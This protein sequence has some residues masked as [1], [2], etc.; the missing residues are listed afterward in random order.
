MTAIAVVVGPGRR[1]A[2]SSRGRPS[3][4][5]PRCSA[6]CPPPTRRRSRPSSPRPRSPTSSPTAA[7][8]SWSRR[9][10][11]T[12]SGSRSAGEG[13]PA[14]NGGGD[15][16]SLLDKQSITSSRLPAAGDLPAR[17]RRRAAP[18]PSRPSTACRPPV[19]HLAV[20]QHDV[21][22]DER[23]RAHRLR[24]GPDQPRPT[25]QAG[26]RS[27]RSCTWSPRRCPSSTADQVTVADSSGRVLNSGGGA[28]VVGAGRRP[29]RSRRSRSRTTP[30]AACRACWTSVVGP[31]HAVV[32][33]DAALNFDQTKVD[34]EEY[35]ADK[36]NP[37]LT[38][39]TTKE[40]YK[41][42]GTPVGGVLGPDNNA[43]PSGTATSG[44]QLLRQAVRQPHQRRRAR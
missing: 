26:R 25:A 8:R 20:P 44:E 16:Y 18:R 29:A 27:R 13:L 33:V 24:A 21:F 38:D 10:T 6:T 31:G 36:T 19:V 39:S 32:R 35:I 4:R 11:S 17:A 12:S 23:R 1:R 40:T 5:T 28:G 22:T 41:G 30:A 14:G 42:A 15:G 3:R 37:P 34:R 7:R 43:V 9:R 2:C